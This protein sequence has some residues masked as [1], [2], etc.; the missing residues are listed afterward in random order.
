MAMS[1]IGAGLDEDRTRFFRLNL[2]IIDELTQ[3]LR[4]L[5]HNEI[6]PT[7]I[8]NTVTGKQKYLKIFRPDEI[9]L[10]STA[11]TKSYND[12]DIT[13][14]YK[15]L[16]NVCPNIPSPTQQWGDPEMPLQN[17]VTVGD[18]IERI[19][20]IRNNVLGHI[21]EAAIPE[22][23]FQEYWS[24]I[25]DISTR[26]QTLLNKDYV[27]RLKKAEECT[28]DSETENKYMDKI[29]QL[30]KEDEDMREILRKILEGIQLI[31]SNLFSKLK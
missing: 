13:L 20:L 21:S 15:L 5:L 28:I 26:M 24:T 25:S 8:F 16:R 18:D 9:A 10:I 7:D 2:V 30:A 11:K 4:D 17:Q 3:I 29:K 14:L 27:R 19:R 6:Q 12:F 23:E 22:T 1:V 31:N